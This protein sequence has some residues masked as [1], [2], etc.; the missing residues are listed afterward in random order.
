MHRG[1]TDEAQF[2]TAL[3][4]SVWTRTPLGQTCLVLVLAALGADRQARSFSVL[5]RSAVTRR[6]MNKVQSCSIVPTLVQARTTKGRLG[7]SDADILLRRV[8]TQ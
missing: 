6:V 1:A 3:S 8:V 2:G 5:S 7:G 4:Q